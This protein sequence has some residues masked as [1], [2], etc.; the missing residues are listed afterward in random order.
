MAKLKTRKPTGNVPWPFILLEG[1]ES[2][3]KTYQAAL[4]SASDKVGTVYWFDLAEGSADEYAAIEGADYEIIEHDGT[5]RDIYEQMQA[6]HD[7]A[8]KAAI[9]GEPPVVLVLDSGSSLW[10]MLKKWTNQ[11]ATRSKKN[12]A[13]LA[14]D[15]DAAIDVAMNLWNDAV[16]RWSDVIHL[17]QTFPGI[18]IMTARGKWITAID[19]NGRPVV[20]RGRAVKEWKVEAQQYTPFDCS[21]WV[22]MKRDDP[23]QVIKARSLKMPVIPG[24]P[25]TIKDFTLEDLIFERLGCSTKTQP[26]QMTALAG[27][28]VTAWLDKRAFDTLTGAEHI[29]TLK[30]VWRAARDDQSLTRPE[31]VAI[32][33]KVEA[34]VIEINE[35]KRDMGDKPPSDEDRLR[36]AAAQ[37]NGNGDADADADGTVI[38]GQRAA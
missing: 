35:P 16:D 25:L 26:R 19:G 3:G 29:E 6:V 37:Q 36:A 18:A 17:L 21:V 31:R 32:Q 20:D 34:R 38:G 23:P 33:A 14:Q 15:P 12:A 24:K 9:A 27:D 22:R 5:Y 1:E 10:K 13:I 8:R 30:G 28:R 2:A 4:L 11:R 7:E